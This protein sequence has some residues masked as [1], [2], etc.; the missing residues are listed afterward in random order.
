MS[1]MADEWAQ[2]MTNRLGA[3]IKEL[4]G[5][6]SVQ[7]LEDRTVELGSRISR[8]TISELETGQRKSIT[9]ADVI[10]LARALDVLAVDLIYPGDYSDTV[11]ALPGVY[12][13][14]GEAKEMIA[15]SLPLNTQMLNLVNSSTLATGSAFELARSVLRENARLRGVPQP[16][17]EDDDLEKAVA[18]LVVSADGGIAEMF[19][20]DVPNSPADLKGANKHGR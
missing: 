5:S 6:R 2:A 13:E 7:W 9:L 11:E 16:A 12:V 17:A 3:Q 14:K 4:R 15:G 20:T 10:V 18:D 8:S 19:L 1:G